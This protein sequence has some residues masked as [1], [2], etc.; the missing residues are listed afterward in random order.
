MSVEQGTKGEKKDEDAAKRLEEVTKMIQEQLKNGV[1]QYQ[2]K[3]A[4][5]G[6]IKKPGT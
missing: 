1:K 4:K 3:K 2:D 5:L 6:L